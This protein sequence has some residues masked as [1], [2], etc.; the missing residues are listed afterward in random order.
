MGKI[1]RQSGLNVATDMSSTADLWDYFYDRVDQILRKQGLFASG[2]EELGERKV[3]LNGKAAPMPNPL[4]KKRGFNIL[5]WTN[6]EA[7]QRACHLAN[8][9]YGTVLAPASHLYFDMAT[10]KNPAEHGVNWGAYIDLDTVYN[11][12][13]FACA[14]NHKLSTAGRKNIR[15]IEGTLF[16]ET[17]RD[18]ERLDFMIM[19]RLLG[20]AERAWATS[21]SW[22]NEPDPTKSAALHRNAWSLFTNQIGKRLLPRLDAEKLNLQYRIA[23]PGL[24]VIDGKVHANHQLPGFDLRYTTDGSEPNVRSTLINGALTTKGLI[25]VAA[26]NHNG[27]KGQS[28][29]I[30]NP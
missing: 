16:S 25:R 10:N 28:S 30:E 24:R 12:N 17:V 4:F 3:M 23:P 15:G 21:P 9:G 22:F 1:A 29:M 13:P 14:D 27:R 11:F 19:P 5:V 7:N 20:L 18:P 8:A 2:W 26:F 6:E